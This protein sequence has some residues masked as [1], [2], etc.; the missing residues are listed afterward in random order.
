MAKAKST[1]AKPAGT[2]PATKEATADKAKPATAQGGVGIRELAESLGV[3]SE[4]SLRARIR[5]INGGP[6]VGRGGRYRWDSMEDPA[7][8]ALVEQLK[9][10]K[11]SA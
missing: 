3:K 6:V 1:T 8:K 9:G 7:L 11:Q 5:R 4:K 10:E 2:K